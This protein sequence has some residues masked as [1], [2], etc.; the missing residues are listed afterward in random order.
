M[1]AVNLQTY[2]RFRCMFKTVNK[3]TGEAPV[4]IYNYMKIRRPSRIALRAST[5]TFSSRAR[6]VMSLLM[7]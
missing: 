1:A 3:H 6:P 4:C 5:P 2:G 7:L